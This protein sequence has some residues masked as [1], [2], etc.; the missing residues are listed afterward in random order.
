MDRENPRKRR[1][2]SVTAVRN[3]VSRVLKDLEA[4]TEPGDVEAARAK[5]YGAK[6]MAEL[7]S[8]TDLENRLRA[9]EQLMEQRHSEAETHEPN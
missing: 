9:L 7:I 6:V 3:Y 1:F 4:Y 5:L 2:R 8:R